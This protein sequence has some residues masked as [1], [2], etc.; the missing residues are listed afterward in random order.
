MTSADTAKTSAT[1]N[2]CMNWTSNE[3]KP[4]KFYL[5]NLTIPCQRVTRDLIICKTDNFQRMSLKVVTV[6]INVKSM[7]KTQS[8]NTV[9][10]ISY[11]N[12]QSLIN[13][14]SSIHF[15][16]SHNT[17]IYMIYCT[18]LYMKLYS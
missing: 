9:I 14:P 2:N 10:F 15:D 3:N 12:T 8:L 17:S 18:I 1:R 7:E 11:K 6:Q 16:N 4:T 5:T 13:L